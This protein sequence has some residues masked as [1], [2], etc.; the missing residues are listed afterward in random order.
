MTFIKTVPEQQ[1]SGATRAMYDEARSA[2]GRIPNMIKAF[3][4][5]PQVMTA[6]AALLA[7]IRDEMD[8]RRYELVTLAAARALRSSYCMLAHGSVLLREFYDAE[9]LRAIASDDVAGLDAADR[10]I[11]RFADKVVRDATAVTEADVDDLREHGLSEAEIFDIAA[12]AAVRCFF[13]KTLDA[14]GAHP[15]ASYNALDADLRRSLTP[16]RPIE[17]R[18]GED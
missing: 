4:H 6:W 18:A 16:G 2:Q 17:E 3:S 8:F 11:M 9:T 15:D 5:R 14:L 12:A 1:A 13:S 10:A 7:S